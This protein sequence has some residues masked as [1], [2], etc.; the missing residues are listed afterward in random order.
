MFSI[1]P[2]IGAAFRRNGRFA[3]KGEAYRNLTL[4]HVTAGIDPEDLRQLSPSQQRQ[5]LPD[6]YVRKFLSGQEG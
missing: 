3:G 4:A 5:V 6:R 2:N 1:L